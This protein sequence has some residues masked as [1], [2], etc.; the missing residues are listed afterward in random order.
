MLFLKKLELYE[1]FS[2]LLNFTMF[3]FTT[4]ERVSLFSK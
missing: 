2:T 1:N 4:A 3:M